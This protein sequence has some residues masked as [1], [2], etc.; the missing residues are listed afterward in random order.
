MYKP[1]WHLGL[2]PALFGLIQ[3][4]GLARQMGCLLPRAGA[5]GVT[6]DRNG[7]EGVGL[8]ESRGHREKLGTGA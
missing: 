8:T 5:G 6:R 3:P 7:P 4:H 2:W 1:T